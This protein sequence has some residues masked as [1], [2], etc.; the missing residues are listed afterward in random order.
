MA[1]DWMAAIGAGLEQEQ[2]AAGQSIQ[3]SQPQP[4]DSSFDTE[5]VAELCR[6]SLNWLAGLA[7][8][9]IFKFNYPKILLAAWKL[10]TEAVLK[11]HDFSQIALGIPRGHAKTTVI[12]L[13]ILFCI[14][15]TK[16]KFILVICSTAQLAENL[17]A[18][19]EDMLNE[20]NIIRVFGDWKLGCTMNRQELKKFG[21][22]GRNITIAAIGAEGSLRGL[23]IKNERPDLMI[24][25]DIQTAECAQSKIQSLT[26]ER[27]MFGT[28]MKAKS[29]AGC[30]FIFCGNMYPGPDSILKK[31]KMNR[32]WI[33][34]ISGAILA[35]GTALWEQLRSLISL[36]AELD[37]DIEAGHA[38][39]FFSEVLN[40]TE[41]GINT[42]TDISQIRIWPWGPSELP[43]GKFIVID[44]SGNTANSDDCVIG[45]YDVFDGQPALRKLISEVLSPGAT[46][47]K[48][49]ILAIE[50]GTR[51]IA[52]ESVAYQAS[53][54]YWFSVICEKLELTGFTFV[55]VHTGVKSKNARIGTML[56]SLTAGEIYIHHDVRTQV[57]HQ[58]AHWNPLKK[59]NEDGILDVL[60]YGSKVIEL[61]PEAI[62][63]ENNLQMIEANGAYVSS[64]NITNPF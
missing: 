47:Y 2:L 5:Q 22:R 40:D 24:F 26:L 58:I 25:E 49:L 62:M 61:Y 13:L 18:D 9:L 52:V 31:L 39:I 19:V 44:P 55:E 1:E 57:I 27:W 64:Q 20:D 45:Q 51:C 59:N 50:T 14:L 3:Q 11:D 32:S 4:E 28:A 12:K 6:L 35:D 38:E 33:K 8:P 29:P 17:I 46:I 48:A 63:L 41:A 53:L 42:R 43:Q 30:T 36:L 37:N 23:N 15:F 56:K 54:L 34:F 16:K 60:C 10:L 21:F 7:M